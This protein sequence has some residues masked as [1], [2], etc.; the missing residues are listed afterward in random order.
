MSSNPRYARRVRSQV[1][2]VLVGLAA[3]AVLALGVP[4]AAS[5]KKPPE[6]QVYI[7][8]HGSPP[9]N[10]PA[11]VHYSAPSKRQSTPHIAGDWVLI[12]P[13][14]YDEE[15]KVTSAHSGIWIRG[16]NRNT[17]IL[18]GQHKVG[19]GIEIVEAE[20]RLGR[21]PDGAQLRIRRRL[22]RRRVRQRDLVER[23]SRA[24]E[25]RSPRLVRQL[26]DR[27]RHRHCKTAATGSS[28]ATRP[29]ASTKTSTPPASPTRASTSA[30]ARN[31]TRRSRTRS[32][33]DNALG[34]SGSNAGGRLVIERSTFAHN[35]VGYRDQL[36]K[37]RRSSAAA[38]RR[39][40][41]AEIPTTTDA[42]RS[43]RRRS[44]DAR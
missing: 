16:M 28:Q 44:R 5:A 22:R 35:T 29:K 17:V 23:R 18:D 43:P 40:Q 12:E 3:L 42:D 19:N 8:S 32:M 20:Q 6:P 14:T 27:L 10:V 41:P 25:D 36:G 9:S 4:A 21:K 37:P 1:R 2:A 7:V 13:G 31:A 30:P 15:V 11:N 26:P 24:R 34:Y 33:E 38:G 39:M